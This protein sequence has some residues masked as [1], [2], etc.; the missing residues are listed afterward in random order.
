MVE[1]YTVYG[2]LCPI[3]L[4][5]FCVVL[6]PNMNIGLLRNTL[7]YLIF[8]VEGPR[9]KLKDLNKQVDEHVCAVS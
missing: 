4:G 3:E 8:E 1:R 7:T 5:I 9:K 2:A 6:A